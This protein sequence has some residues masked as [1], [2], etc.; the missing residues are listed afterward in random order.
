DVSDSGVLAND[1]S[2]SGAALSAGIFSG[3]AHGTVEL[4]ADGSFHYVPEADFMGL[5][6]FLYFANDGASDSMLAAV[7]IDVGDGGPPPQAAD[8]SYSVDEDGAL[9]VAFSDGLLAN[10]TS[11]DDATLSSSLVSGPA[12]GTLSLGTDGSFTYVPNA[13][14]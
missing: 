14:F 11:A 3:P 13:N 10:D 6:S 1:T 9:S 4:S 12:T 5:D 2:T 8:D 7:T